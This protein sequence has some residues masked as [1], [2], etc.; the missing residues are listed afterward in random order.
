MDTGDHFYT[1]N[2][3][4]RD[5]V[6][7]NIPAYHYEGVAFEAYANPATVGS[8]G[9]TMER[10]YNTVTQKHMYTADAGEIKA[11]NGGQAGAGWV[12]EGHAFTVHV[13]TTDGL[14]HV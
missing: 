13:S 5:A 14:L 1:T 6:L 2:V 10:F 7:K 8:S 4:E 11:I 3:A 9:E 12:D